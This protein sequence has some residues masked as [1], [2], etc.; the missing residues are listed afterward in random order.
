MVD[1]A[2]L[3]HTF[4]IRIVVLEWR[5]K[6]KR[7]IGL[8]LILESVDR[9]FWSSA[10]IIG[11]RETLGW[12]SNEDLTH[13]FADRS[14][15]IYLNVILNLSLSYFTSQSRIRSFLDMKFALQYLI[16]VILDDLKWN[17][18]YRR[19]FLSVKVFLLWL[20]NFHYWAI[21]K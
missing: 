10:Q 20:A 4:S 15:V 17:S 1:L 13:V 6:Q 9:N 11:I 19:N 8:L 3:F 12:L 7:A 2:Q 14:T 5:W 21:L 16:V 18:W